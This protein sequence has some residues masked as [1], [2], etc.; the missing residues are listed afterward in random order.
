MRKR[1]LIWLMRTRL[2]RWFMKDVIW[3][4]R[5]SLYY[6]TI[7]GS[8]YHQGYR[9]LTPGHIVLTVDRK[10]LTSLLIPGEMTHAALCVGLVRDGAPYE[11]AEMTHT[12]YTKSHF[13][14]ICK[15]ADRV[16]IMECVDFDADYVNAMT[17]RCFSLEGSKYDCEFSLGVEA[18]Y[19]SELIYQSDIG[20]R[21]LVSLEDLAGLGRPYIS[22]DGLLFGANLVCIWDSDCKWTGW[23]GGQIRRA[24]KGA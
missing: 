23:T 7:R 4:I 3:W 2:F 24:V 10:K 17:R 19:C 14:D 5:W 1:F 21:L 13:F 11:I 9:H 20:K 12:D 16:V 15:E 6:A 22:P 18:L 8:A